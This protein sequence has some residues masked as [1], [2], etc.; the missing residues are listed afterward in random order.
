VPSP[1]LDYRTRFASVFAERTGK[2][3]TAGDKLELG[4]L[5][6]YERRYFDSFTL[7]SGI[8]PSEEPY[9]ALLK[10]RWLD[11]REALR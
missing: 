4:E 9:A 10:R 1:L 7:S 11:L 5:R 8:G 6:D 2:R 3:L